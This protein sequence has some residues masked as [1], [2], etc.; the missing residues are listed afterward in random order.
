MTKVLMLVELWQNSVVS[1]DHVALYCPLV[2]DAT[3][4]RSHSGLSQLCAHFQ[5]FQKSCQGWW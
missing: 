2:G 5:H 3:V 4:S 1:F